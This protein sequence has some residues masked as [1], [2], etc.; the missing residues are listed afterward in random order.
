MT[1]NLC[2]SQKYHKWDHF[3]TFTCNA[4]Q[5][6]GTAP[7]KNWV[8]NCGWEKYYQDFGELEED[9]KEEIQEAIINASAG[10]ILRVWEE[11]TELFLDYLQKSPSSPFNKV[12]TFF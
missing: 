11:A 12:L 4:K 10:L 8:D 5:H 3:L 7:I 9:E 1:R 2:A 6:F